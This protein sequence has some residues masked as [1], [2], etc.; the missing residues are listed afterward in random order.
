MFESVYNSSVSPAS[1]A[2]MAAAALV[3]GVVYAWVMS[4]SIHSSKRFFL[5]RCCRSSWRR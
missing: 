4:F 1:V 2:L 3:S 5:V